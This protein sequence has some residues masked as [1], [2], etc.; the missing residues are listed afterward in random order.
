M[1][2]RSNTLIGS[3]II[4]LIVLSILYGQVSKSTD[5]NSSFE[6]KLSKQN[7]KPAYTSQIVLGDLDS[8]GD[9]DAVFAN[10]REFHY[11]KIWI[12]DGKGNF[13]PTSQDL[14]QQPSQDRR[15]NSLPLQMDGLREGAISR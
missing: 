15:F 5:K 4:S 1:K 8:D 12:N 2:S 9:L 14:T 13:T 11:S 10:M 3:L 7:F 6:F